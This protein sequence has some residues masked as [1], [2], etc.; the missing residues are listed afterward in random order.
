MNYYLV[1]TGNMAW[2]LGGRLK[3]AG[4]QCKGVYGRKAENAQTMAEH[5]GA[6]VLKHLSDIQDDA[7]CCIIAVSDHSIAGVA[8]D[9]QLKNTV[10]IHTAGA[11]PLDVIRK[12]NKAVLWFIYSILKTELPDH[13]AIPAMWEANGEPAKRVVTSIAGAISDIVMEGNADKRTWLHL[14]AVFANNFTNHI[15]TIC[16][17]ICHE[18]GVSFKL[19]MPILQQT[20]YRINYKSPAELQT[21]PAVRRDDETVAKH[22]KLLADTPERQ[23][24]YR[25]VTQSIEDMYNSEGEG[26]E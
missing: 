9:L 19:M 17:Q 25:A 13:R 2:F 21:G 8:N 3:D 20:L 12:E 23:R 22:L 5:C 10:V 11:V 26:K 6:T 7:D 1:G 4:H 18:Q 24:I 16:E 15:V 14:S